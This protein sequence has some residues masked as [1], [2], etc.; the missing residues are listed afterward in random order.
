MECPDRDK[1]RVVK[2]LASYFREYYEA[3]RDR[4][5][6]GEFQRRLGIGPRLKHPTRI[7]VAFRSERRAHAR[8]NPQRLR[9]EASATGLR[10]AKLEQ[11]PRP[12]CDGRHPT[13]TCGALAQLAIDSRGAG[14][15]VFLR[16]LTTNRPKG[17]EGT[18]CRCCLSIAP[19]ATGCRA[20]PERRLLSV[21][22]SQIMRNQMISVR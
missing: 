9:G 22:R 11:S 1:F 4:R 7:G 13:R 15:R 5:R 16:T 6:A 18:A 20:I 21:I 10:L 14:G 2:E 3:E 8:A 12:G 19:G 17:K